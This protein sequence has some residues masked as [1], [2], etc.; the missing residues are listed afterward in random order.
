MFTSHPTQISPRKKSEIVDLLTRCV[1]FLITGWR[2][3]MTMIIII[4]LLIKLRKRREAG[5]IG[6]F[7]EKLRV[8]QYIRA[9]CC[10]VFPRPFTLLVQ[11]INNNN[12]Q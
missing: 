12:G 2:S 4:D 3:I 5:R 8:D 11:F 1:I 7:P 6:C 9:I 10:G